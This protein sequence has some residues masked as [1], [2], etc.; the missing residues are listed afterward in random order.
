MQAPMTFATD[1][2][3]SR[4]RQDSGPFLGPA[5]AFGMTRGASALET[6]AEEQGQAGGDG[7]A[8]KQRIDARHLGHHLGDVLRTVGGDGEV[9]SL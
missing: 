6:I 1:L 4:G 7:A 8:L 5:R 2:R 9:R 3:N